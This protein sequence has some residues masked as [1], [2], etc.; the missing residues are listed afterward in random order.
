MTASGFPTVRACSFHRSGAVPW[1]ALVGKKISSGSRTV[2]KVLPD[3]GCNGGGNQGPIVGAVGAS[4]ARSAALATGHDPLDHR[5]FAAVSVAHPERPF[6]HVRGPIPVAAHPE[7]VL[8]L[9]LVE[10]RR[11]EAVP[12]HAGG[13]REVQ[14]RLAAGKAGDA[15]GALTPEQLQP[16]HLHADENRRGAGNLAAG[17]LDGHLDDVAPAPLRT[18]Q[19]EGPADGVAGAI[20]VAAPP[21]APLPRGLVHPQ[22]A[23]PV[24]RDG[25]LSLEHQA[26]AGGG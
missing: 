6:H 23:D 7:A 11:G 10:R 4:G 12:G 2:Q 22:A 16:I 3:H 14:R 21:E 26:G 8:A 9:V 20:T 13:A 25:R 18:A 15:V 1:F 19:G 17:A 5:A 24:T